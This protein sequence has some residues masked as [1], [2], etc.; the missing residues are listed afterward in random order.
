MHVL[1]VCTGNICRSPTAERLLFALARANGLHGIQA[2]SAG[3]RAVV[4]HPI[5]PEAAPVLERLGGDSSN[6]AARQLTAKIASAADL[7]LTMTRAHRDAVLELA[8][9]RLHRT[10]TLAEASRLIFERGARTVPDLAARRSLLTVD[11]LLD[12][13]DPI[14][15]SPE[16]FAEIGSQIAHLLPPIFEVCQPD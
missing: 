4:G 3:A 2:S 5:H 11:E 12:I 6:F 13:P 16:V 15:Q 9:H 10:F 8:P 14:G 1:F 7:I